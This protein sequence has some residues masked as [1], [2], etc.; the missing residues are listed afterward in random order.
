MF[1]LANLSSQNKF[2]LAVALIWTLAWKGV[3]LWK[4]AGR[5]EKWWFI[6]F[7]LINTLGV[8]EIAYL[9][10]FSKKENSGADK[11]PERN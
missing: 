1:N 3:A 8:L 7:L 2:L 10:Y 9:Y 6:A 4:S 11:K 5:K